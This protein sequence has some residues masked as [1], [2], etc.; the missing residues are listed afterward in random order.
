MQ[1]D[2][3]ALFPPQKPGLVGGRWPLISGPY[4]CVLGAVFYLEWRGLVAV[5][6]RAA[7]IILRIVNVEIV[8][9]KWF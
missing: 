8:G 9:V 1:G 3:S 2:K 4:R 7:V 5:E 6:A